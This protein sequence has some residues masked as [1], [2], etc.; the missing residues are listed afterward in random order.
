MLA[1]GNEPL[2]DLD[3]LKGRLLKFLEQPLHKIA[4]LKTETIPESS[5]IYAIYEN[6][7]GNVQPRI[8]YIGIVTEISARPRVSTGLRFRIWEK[9]CGNRGEDDF[10]SGLKELRRLQSFEDTQE[11]LR[12]NCSCRWLEEGDSGLLRRLEHFSIA[13]LNPP[14]NA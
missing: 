14:F 11:Y 3:L 4:N 9:H 13:L 1:Q 10:R 2:G 6:S 12:S 7:K 8:M 5:G